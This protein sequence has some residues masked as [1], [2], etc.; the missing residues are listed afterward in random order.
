MT[1]RRSCCRSSQ[2]FSITQ[3]N[4]STKE[5]EPVKARRKLK[6]RKREVGADLIGARKFTGPHSER[7]TVCD[8]LDSLVGDLE[9]RQKLAPQVASKMKPPRATLGWMHR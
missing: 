3:K 1:T 8:I 5:T 7:I 6:Q 9:I 4:E 2:T